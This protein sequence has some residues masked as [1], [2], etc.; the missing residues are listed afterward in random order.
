MNLKVWN[1]WHDNNG[2]MR[3]F[4]HT[5]PPGSYM[6]YRWKPGPRLNGRKTVD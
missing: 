2:C 4:K 6:H 1:D 5:L 3:N